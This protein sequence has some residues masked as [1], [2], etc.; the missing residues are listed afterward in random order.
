MVPA[1]GV[2][3][4]LNPLTALERVANTASIAMTNYL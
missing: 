4:D 3:L 1:G 2:R